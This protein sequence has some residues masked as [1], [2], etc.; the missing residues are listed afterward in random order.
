MRIRQREASHAILTEVRVWGMAEP[1]ARDKQGGRQ[2]ATVTGTTATASNY[3]PALLR[4]IF[5]LRGLRFG[6]DP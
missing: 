4:I 2:R 6:L 3:Y 5:G 1:G